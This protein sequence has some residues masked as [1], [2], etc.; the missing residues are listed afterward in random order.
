MVVKL[1]DAPSGA[2]KL[3]SGLV[4]RSVLRTALADGVPIEVEFSYN[5]RL[6]Y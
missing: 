5:V 2:S 3:R 4:D 6:S 1:P